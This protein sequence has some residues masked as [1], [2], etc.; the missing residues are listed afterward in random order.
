MSAYCYPN[1]KTKKALKETI[2]SGGKVTAAENTPTGKQ[3]IQDG[4]A[5]LEGP[6]YPEAHKWYA[7]AIIKDGFIVKVS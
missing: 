2:A 5:Y 4:V 3:P 7:K 1:H 6:H